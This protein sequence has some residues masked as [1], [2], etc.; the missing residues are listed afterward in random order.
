M[1]LK[2][3][4]SNPDIAVKK[5][6]IMIKEITTEDKTKLYEL[7]NI[8]SNKVIP[9]GFTQITDKILFWYNDENDSTRIVQILNN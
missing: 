8:K 2:V 5:K 6:I 7:A 3:F 9:L 4:G 1:N